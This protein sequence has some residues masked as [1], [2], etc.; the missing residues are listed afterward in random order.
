MDI[1]LGFARFSYFCSPVVPTDMISS[2]LKEVK[3]VFGAMVLHSQ[4]PSHLTKQTTYIV[5]H[6]LVKEKVKG[7]GLHRR[8][9][10]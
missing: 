2:I 3:E 10:H 4:L 5:P 9:L 1:V 6:D 7:Q 8:N